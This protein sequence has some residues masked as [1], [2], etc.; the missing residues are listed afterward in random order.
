[1]SDSTPHGQGLGAHVPDPGRTLAQWARDTTRENPWPLHM[2]STNIKAYLDKMSEM[3]VEGQIVEYKARPANKMTFFVL[4]DL[5]ENASMQVK[6]FGS[7]IS[8]AGPA[9][10]SGARVVMRIKPDYY[11]GNGQL[12][13]MAKEI[14]TVGLGDMLAQIEK[15]RAQLQSEGLFAPE[16]K[17]PLPFLP[18]CIGLITGRN[19]DGMKDVLENARKRWPNIP[20]EIREV[21]VQGPNSPA[22]VTAALRELD[23]LAHVD[24]IIIA[25][26]GGSV[27]DLLGFSDEGLVR[28]AASAQTP[29]VSAIG[30]DADTPLLDYVADLRASTPTDAAKRVVPDWAEQMA[31]VTEGRARLSAAVRTR[32]QRAREDLQ[33]WITRPVLLN[34]MQIV[35]DKRN[36]LEQGIAALHT[37]MSGVLSGYGQ[38]LAELRGSLRSLSPQSTLERGYAVLRLPG[39]KVLTSSEQTKKGDLLEAILAEGRLIATVFGTTSPD[40]TTGTNT[41]TP[42]T[43]ED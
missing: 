33:A 12:A 21:L 10:D 13:L 37:R 7:V 34:P 36:D 19:S 32:F 15:L 3:W 40:G 5:Q 35:D 30:H 1:M 41:N 20:F 39:A 6:A 17:K 25:R 11:V 27:E 24:V 16:R 29:I 4:K 28:A 26:G 43:Q 22:E 9:L 14:H 2:L 23:G 38:E 31:F 8:S 42:A 18:N